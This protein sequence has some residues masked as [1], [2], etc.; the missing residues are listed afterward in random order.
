[1]STG[2]KVNK[3]E[4]RGLS[5]II[6]VTTKLL[7]RGKLEGQTEKTENR[8]RDRK[9]EVGG[10]WSQEWGQHLEAGIGWGCI[11]SPREQTINEKKCFRCHMGIY[12]LYSYMI[13]HKYSERM[14]TSI[15]FQ[16]YFS[17]VLFFLSLK[18]CKSCHYFF[19]CRY[20]WNRRKI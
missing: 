2:L 20:F 8:S 11:C 1:M 16:D 10:A 5:W 3:F 18:T 9:G 6:Q 19:S 13:S 15:C 12:I 4:I 14:N 17:F 7:V